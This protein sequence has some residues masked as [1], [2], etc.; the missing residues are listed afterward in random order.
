[1]SFFSRLFSQSAR[2]LSI[3][4]SMRLL[5]TPASSVR[6]ALS[7]RV[8]SAAATQPKSETLLPAVEETKRELEAMNSDLVGGMD[9]PDAMKSLMRPGMSMI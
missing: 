5:N 3:D 7:R 8:F 1:M 4:P 2:P 9:Q 6:S